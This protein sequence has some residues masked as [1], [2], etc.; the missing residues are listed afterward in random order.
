MASGRE[1]VASEQPDFGPSGYLPQRAAKRARKIMLREPMGLQWAIAAVIAGMLVVVAGTVA[2]LRMT[3]PPDAPFVAAAQLSAVG[4]GAVPIR[5]PG[6]ADMVVVRHAGGITVFAAPDQPVS[7]C[8]ESGRLESPDGSVWQPDGRRVGGHG[9]SL[10][11][12]PAVVHGGVIYVD[13]TATGTSPAPR[14]A[15]EAAPAC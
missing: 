9:T 15:Q 1:I 2:V 4:S 14:S 5:S 12:L 10:T 8:A 13:P 3:G 7:W 11:R 6:G